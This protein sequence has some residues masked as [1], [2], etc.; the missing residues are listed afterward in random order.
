[1]NE[2]KGGRNR[3]ERFS[4]LH[5]GWA[6]VGAVVTA[7]LLTAFAAV[8]AGGSPGGTST[9]AAE[10]QYRKRITICHRSG[11]NLKRS[12]Y[13]TIRIAPRAWRGHQRHGDGRGPCSRAVFTICHKTKAGKKRTV[14]VR[15]VKVRGWKAHRKHMRHGDKIRACPKKKK[16]KKG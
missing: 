16:K 6:V 11:R 3:M 14:K 13:R 4:R 7:L 2:T 9:P 8:G 12:K 5:L 15:T 10:D 1:M